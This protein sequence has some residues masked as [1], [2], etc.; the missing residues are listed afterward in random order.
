MRVLSTFSGIGGFEVG[1]EHALPG[2]TLLA[3]NEINPWAARI[4]E[5]HLGGVNLRVAGDANETP[6]GALSTRE[7]SR[8]HDITGVDF[9]RFN[10]CVDL[11]VGGPPCQDLSVGVVSH[12]RPENVRGH[13]SRHGLDGER[14]GLFWQFVRVIRETAPHHVL[15]ENVASMRPSDRDAIT[16]AL[17]AVHPR[18]RDPVEIN[19]RLV[20]AQNRPR[21]FWATW[22]VVAP[23][24]PGPELASVLELTGP[25]MTPAAI[26]LMDRYKGTRQRWYGG[27]TSFVSERKSKCV[28]R[29]WFKGVP[30]RT[31]VDDRS[32]PPIKRKFSLTEIERLQGFPDGW[33]AVAGASDTQ[34]IAALGNAVSP[35]VVAAAMASFPAH[36]LES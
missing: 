23:A 27:W 6:D 34:R 8:V 18:I 2:A 31:L 32:A 10:G 22:D 7:F 9:N 35:P 19:A 25:A 16:A 20:T 28:T 30:Y 4:Y 1:I 14:S 13:M 33:T 12:N 36:G 26:A 15:M 21:L 24:G 3:H 17:R 11:L 29:V 5:T